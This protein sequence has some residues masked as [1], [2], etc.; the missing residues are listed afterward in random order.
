MRVSRV[1]VAV[2]TIVTTTLAATSFAA[3]QSPT[4]GRIVAF[5]DS[6]TDN[7]NRKATTGNP[8]A[9]YFN[10]RFSN[11]P[12]WVE[13]VSGGPMNSPFQGTGIGGNT[14]LAFGGALAG[15][16]NNLVQFRRSR[17]RFK[18]SRRSAANTDRAISRPSGAAPTTCSSTSAR[19][20]LA[21]ASR[22]PAS[23][24]TRTARRRR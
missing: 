6:L 1:R 11:G 19:T 9:P 13:I 5:G 20:V 7:G 23:W 21:P 22:P 15:P 3:A 17:S 24:R 2:A 4:G 10:G 14:N 18:P 12:T 8:G 16:G